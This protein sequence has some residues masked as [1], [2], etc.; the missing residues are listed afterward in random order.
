MDKFHYRNSF[1]GLCEFTEILGISRIELQIC[2]WKLYRTLRVLQAQEREKKR[3]II[4]KN[5]IRSST[6]QRWSFLCAGTK[7]NY[8]NV[9]KQN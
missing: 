4:V 3:E 7:R 1:K 8:E 9:K 2:K 6:E 5:L